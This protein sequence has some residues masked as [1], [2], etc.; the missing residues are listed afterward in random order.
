MVPHV[1]G[2]TLG[3]GDYDGLG[4]LESTSCV[5]KLWLLGG[6]EGCAM[7]SGPGDSKEER[8]SKRLF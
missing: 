7:E 1:V 2:R 4:E 8:K 6:P 3:L 5:L